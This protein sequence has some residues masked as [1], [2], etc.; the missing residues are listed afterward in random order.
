M[1]FS[2]LSLREQKSLKRRLIWLLVLL[3]LMIGLSFVW[4]LTPARKLLDV[5]LIIATFLGF[6]NTVGPFV[7]IG[8]FAVAVSVAV[9]LTFLILVTILSFGPLLGFMYAL[10]G[11][12]IG[13]TI[14]YTVGRMLGREAIMRFGG[15][16]IN[17]ISR[18]LAGR[19]I[20]AII[21]IRMVP[22]A[23]F[24]VINIVIGASHIRLRDLIIGTAIGMLPG[25]LAMM[26]FVDQIIDAFNHPGPLTF[27]LLLLTLLLIGFGVW[28][29]RRWLEKAA[30]K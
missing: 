8:G 24:A 18:R 6:G 28:G 22:I 16:R 20:L 21:A 11:A 3:V 27:F 10:S 26:F 4:G 14:S 23:P 7:A 30:P 17:D 13:A 15:N 12:M 1:T 2:E 29:M 5:D 19:G 25:M 9:P